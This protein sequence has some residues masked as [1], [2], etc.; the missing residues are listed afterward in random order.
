MLAI[1]F[2]CHEIR[3]HKNR[4]AVAVM[5]TDCLICFEAHSTNDCP[6]RQPQH[7]PSCH[8]YIKLLANHS[9]VCSMKQWSYQPYKNLCATPPL[10]RLIVGCNAPFRFL[11]DGDWRQTFDGL[12][13]YSPETGILI[14]FKNK[15]DFCCLT[16]SF[17]P[18]RIA[19]VVKEKSE[20]V[21]KLMLLASPT[22]FVVAVNLNEPFD[23]HAAQKNHQWKTTLILGLASTKDLRLAVMVTPPRQLVRRYELPY[24]QSVEKFHVP[25]ELA[26]ATPASKMKPSCHQENNQL[27]VVANQEVNK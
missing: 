8:I 26:V 3:F 14:R 27:V 5:D 22:R 12:E 25:E 2:F 15:N 16:R 10:E 24:D 19:F 7:C 13:L 4:F 18:I 17:A 20:F 1:C 21:V 11:Y 6:E 23:R 9:S